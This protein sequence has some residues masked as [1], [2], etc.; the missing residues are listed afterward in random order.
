MNLYGAGTLECHFKNFNFRGE[1]ACDPLRLEI[2]SPNQYQM[3]VYKSGIWP[4]YYL[5]HTKSDCIDFRI[6][7]GIPVVSYTSYVVQE[8]QN[9][10]TD[11]CIRKC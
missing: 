5:P 11:G 4:K 9:T 10:A 8:S 7:S 1:A 2:S 6:T 3:L